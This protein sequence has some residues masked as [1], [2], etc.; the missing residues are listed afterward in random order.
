MSN[1][2]HCLLFFGKGKHK[3]NA[4]ISKGVWIKLFLKLT[5]LV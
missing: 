2:E 5:G 4:F 3:K 1:F